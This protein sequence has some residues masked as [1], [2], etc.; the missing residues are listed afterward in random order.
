MSA[1]LLAAHLAHGASDH[2]CDNEPQRSLPF[3]DPMLPL[4]A[5]VDD[6]VARIPL[7]EIP[8]LLGDNS[9]GSPSAGLPPY[10]WWS[11]G[12]HG[13]ALSPAVRFTAPTTSATSFPMI[14]S[15]ASSFNRT[16][17]QAMGSVI[18]T[19]ARSFHSVGHGGLTYWAPNM[20]IYR[21]PRWGRGQETPGEDPFVTAAYATAFVR[22][23][24]GNERFLKVS[25]CC[26]HFSAYSQE[27]DRHSLS[28]TVSAQDAAD[29]YLP[30]FEACVRD[31]GASS[32]MCSYNAVN[33]VPSCADK[34]LLTELLRETWGFDGYVVSDCGAVDDIYTHHKYTNSTAATC[35]ATL[36]AGMDLNCGDF[37]QTHLPSALRQGLVRPATATRALQQL[38]RVQ[39]R[40]GMFE[41]SR[42]RPYQD[43]TIDDIDTPA[44]RQLAYE[45]AAQSLVLLHN[46]KLLP[47]DVNAFTPTHRLVLLGPHVNATI[48]LLGS[49]AG[50]PTSIASP[51]DGV[52]TFVSPR[53]LDAHAAC[54][55]DGGDVD[56]EAMALARAN[57]TRQIVLFLGLNQSLEA[58]GM[59][60][61]HLR[62]PDVQ[63]ALFRAVVAVAA[64]PIVVVLL[65]GGAVDL[66]EIKH[67]PRVGAI[68][69]AGYLGQAGGSA[70]ADVLFGQVNPSGRLSQTLYFASFADQV[71]MSDMNMRPTARTPGRTH[72][73]YN[74]DVV[75]P[76][77]HGLSYTTFRYDV[78]TDDDDNDATVVVAGNRWRAAIR[79]T[80]VGE[81]I[82][83]DILLC[84]A[85]PPGAGVDGKP[86]QSLVA[87]EKVASLVPGDEYIWHL[88]L[89]PSAFAVA[90][91]DGSTEILPGTWTIAVGSVRID[92]QVVTPMPVAATSTA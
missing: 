4:S 28:A 64:S 26:K 89:P 10:G 12:L 42:T 74:G 76:F 9:T 33:G 24:Q 19:E 49:Y 25:A 90:T 7:L 88:D 16:L 3:C 83:D 27:V 81:L 71:T 21:D 66:G 58:E 82:G 60:R 2:V 36:S 70:I 38:L 59:D 72:R 63:L 73:F 1:L 47:L 5:R 61:T 65:T 53:Y 43:I 11:E 37:V 18:A 51:L 8:G 48:A 67:H 69:Y 55:V 77:G 22:G 85:S 78:A 84:F 68:L 92:V 54:A 80:N 50:I 30:A 35:D 34:R 23:M 20:N 29:T 14:I 46:T 13:V 44:H 91:Q 32:V 6:L 52:E 15:V 75:F 41:P 40:L 86:K 45:A 79:I 62:L 56:D 31:G 87:F 17:W 57:T 39:F